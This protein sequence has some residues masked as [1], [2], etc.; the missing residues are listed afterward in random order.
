M[1]RH[2]ELAALC[3]A[4]VLD[5]LYAQQA[6][7]RIVERQGIQEGFCSTCRDHATVCAAEP[8]TSCCGSDL[9]ATDPKEN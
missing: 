3:R 8:L 2:E 6:A 1:T 5:P 4:I 9:L 7:Q